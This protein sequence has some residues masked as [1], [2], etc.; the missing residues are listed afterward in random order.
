MPNATGVLI[1]NAAS[2]NTIGGTLPLE[3]NVI[4]GNTGVGVRIPTPSINNKVT[5]NSIDANGGLGIDV[6][7]C[8]RHAERHAGRGPRPELPDDHE[9]RRRPPSAARSPSL[10]E[11]DV[12]ASR[13]SRARPATRPANGEGARYVGTTTMTT[14]AAGTGTFSATVSPLQAGRVV[15]ATATSP[16]RQHVGVLAVRRDRAAADRDEPEPD[17]DADERAG[18]R[19][20]RQALRRA[21]DR[22]APAAVEP[23]AVA[24]EPDAGQP[25]ADQPARGDRRPVNQTPDQPDAGQPDAG[26]PAA[27]PSS[28]QTIPA[29]GSI[30]SRRIPAAARRA[31]GPRCSP[32]RRSRRSRSR[33]SRCATSTRSTRR[34]RR[35][36]PNATNPITLGELDLSHSTLGGMPAMAFAL[37]KLPLSPISVTQHRH[38]VHELVPRRAGA[39]VNCGQH[40]DRPVGRAAGRARQPDAGQPDAGQP[41]ADQRARRR[42]TRRSTRRRSTRRRSTRRASARCPVNQT[43]VN[44]TPVNQTPVNQLSLQAI[45]AANAP[46]NQTPVNQPPVNQLDTPNQ[47]VFC[48]P[49]RDRHDTVDCATRDA[50]QRLRRARD[51]PGR[52]ARRPAHTPTS[53]RANV[54]RELARS[55]PNPPL[56]RRHDDRRPAREPA[57]AEHLHA[58]ATCF[59]L[60]LGS[61]NARRASRSRAQHLRHRPGAVRD[62]RQHGRLPRAVQ[63]A[64]N[65]GPTGVPSPVTVTSTLGTGFLYVAG[66][67]KLLPIGGNCATVAP[68]IADPASTTLERRPAQAHVDGQH[69]RRQQLR[70][71]FTAR[72]GIVLGPQAASLDAQPGGGPTASATRRRRSTSA[73]RSSRTTTPA[74]GAADLQR[75]LLPLVP[76]ELVGRRLLPLRGAAGGHDDDVPPQPPAGGLRPRRLRPAGDA[77]AAAHHRRRAARRA[78]GHRRRRRPDARDRPAPVADARRP[79]PPADL[80][81]VGVSASRGTDP[82]DVVV[83]SP[84][85]GGFYTVQVTGYNGA[86][87]PKPYMLRVA[88]TPPRTT[89]TVAAADDHRHR[90]PGAADALPTGSTRSSSSTGSSCEGIY[91]STRRV[92]RHDRARERQRRVHEPRLPERRALRRPLRRRA[93]RVHGVER[94]IPG[95]RPRRTASS[96]AINGVVDTQIRSQP[97]GAG[98]KYLVIVGGDQVI[99][100]ARLDDFTVTAGNEAGYA[101]TFGHEH[102]PLLRRSTPGRCSPTIRTATS[103]PV[104]YLTRQLYIPELAVGRLVETP[105]DIIGDAQPLRRTRPS[106]A[107]STRRRRSRRATT[108]SSTARAA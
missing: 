87:S 68:P 82:E 70:V 55:S 96:Q 92:E 66:S 99:P 53:C 107:T 102:R 64:P 108:S 49:P 26:R 35:S 62:R 104:P 93:D 94:A 40:G 21:A 22:A 97:N 10:A 32:A 78:A 86:T 65:G 106:A 36:Q 48:A 16:Q 45:L 4:S 17:A 84:G 39:G 43:P 61:P 5:R 98:L 24:G 89:S 2:G 38:D 33:T 67:S 69:D 12:H 37:G 46:V 73:T 57:A 23:A 54:A 20:A 41:D 71:C 28:T 91:G 100:F 11:H 80:P 31:A 75:L 6:A 29:L 19:A 95:A 1:D 103:N 63:R 90:R 51:P 58:R 9:R 52:H 50:G 47:I 14:N 74:H 79:A 83:V 77:A 81:L 101:S 59:L 85:G 88:T 34:R 7:G 25:D 42:T 8:R 15:T 56:L 3:P 18:R 72:P 13:S 27:S 76:D 44:Q 105:D 60:V 30:R